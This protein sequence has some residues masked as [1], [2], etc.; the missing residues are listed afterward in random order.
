MIL[1]A[2]S[3]SASANQQFITQ[4][5][6]PSTR[7]N[8]SPS[9]TTSARLSAADRS[10]VEQL[11]ANLSLALSQTGGPS[12]EAGLPADGQPLVSDTLAAAL[13]K[14]LA[15]NRDEE[16]A[17]TP[18][19]MQE[20][21]KQYTG[22][23]QVL[24]RLSEL[25]ADT[26]PECLQEWSQNHR[27]QLEQSRDLLQYCQDQLK[28]RLVRKSGMAWYTLWRMLYR[29]EPESKR[30]LRE[31]AQ[32]QTA[33]RSLPNRVDADQAAAALT[34]PRPRPDL[35]HASQILQFLASLAA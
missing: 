8:N 26:A 35:E 32:M 15:T 17:L 20:M 6:S 23:Q 1:S 21:M 29:D 10:K 28:T 9:T 5:I 34:A 18:G 4:L 12:G 7:I 27:A 14:L 13:Q 33:P 31:E 22:I 25:M 16:R 11:L 2:Y 24:D 30:A 19:E 3:G